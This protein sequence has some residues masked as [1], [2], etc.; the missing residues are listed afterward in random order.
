M[1]QVAV[2]DFAPSDGTLRAGFPC[3][4]RREIIMEK[5]T[6]FPVVEGIV[7]DLFIGFGAESNGGE[8]LGFAAC[9]DSRAVRAGQ[10]VGF[11]P[12]GADFRSLAPVK[13]FA[14][15]KDGAAHGFFFHIVI[16]TT[17]HFALF[18]KFFFRKLRFVFC[19]YFLKGFGTFVF[20][21][22]GDGYGVCPVVAFCAYVLAESFVVGF[23]VVFALGQCADG[24]G[25]FKLGFTL[26]F[27]VF[28]SN[29]DSFKHFRFL[30]FVHFAFHHHDVVNRGSHHDVNVSLFKLGESGIDNE[31]AVDAC[32]AHFRD[33]PVERN[34][35]NSQ[36]GGGS[37][38]GKRIRHVFAVGREQYD[39][40]KNLSMIVVR[41]ERAQ[42]TI[43]QT[44]RKNFIVGSPAFP[45]RET[46]G[47]TSE[48]G[49]LFLV[50]HLQRHKVCPRIC[51]FGSRH[52][53]KQYSVV[54]S[55][56]NRTVGLFRQ[57]PCF[58]GDRSPVA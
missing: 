45:P 38:S 16:I 17:Y 44:G 7:D 53:G 28:V 33:R 42:G 43:N 56:G 3:G 51:L 58:D 34:V 41:K 37:Q 27:D 23:V 49:E 35:G 20:V 26:Q 52:G 25:E 32:N 46:A 13:P 18:G 39:I 8:G 30:H 1:S 47:E 2:T 24:F 55:N 14:F 54:H 10:V 15:I 57:F 21:A 12:D 29:F 31:L 48:S 19:D 36:S 11:Y 22:A 40:Y 50:L 6:L 9:K 5:E 4:E